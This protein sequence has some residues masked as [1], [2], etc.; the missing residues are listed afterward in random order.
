M[1]E[2]YSGEQ[3]Q[4]CVKELHHRNY[5]LNR[6]INMNGIGEWK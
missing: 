1:D 4:K 3:R 2:L 6:N 5:C